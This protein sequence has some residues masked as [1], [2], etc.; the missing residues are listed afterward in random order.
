MKNKYIRFLSLF[1]VCVTAFTRAQT[2]Y[3]YT[4]KPMFQLSIK[5]AGIPIGSFTV[6]LFPNI[7]PKHTRNFDSLVSQKFYDTTA[8]HR[9]I[10]G[11]MIQGGDPNSRHGATSTW[12]YGQ[13]GQP[14]VQ[15]EFSKAKHLRG[16]LS[17][18][19]LANNVNS[20]TSQFF[21]CVAAAP[22]LDGNY[23]IYGRVTKNM[24]LVDTIVNAPRNAQDR[25][26]LKHE[27]F[28]TYIGSN[29]TVPMA[30]TLLQPKM[31][32]VGIDSTMLLQLKWKAVSDGIIYNVEV[33]HDSTFATT[34][35]AY[36]VGSTLA[37]FNHMAGNTRYYWRVRTNN[38]GHFS[39]WTQAWR[40]H[41]AGQTTGLASVAANDNN[42]RVFPNPGDEHFNFVNLNPGSRIL[43]YDETGKLVSDTVSTTRSYH[44][45]LPPKA[46]GYY[47]YS[48][49]LNN[50]E[51]AK[52]KLLLR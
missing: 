14:T 46:K 18:A 8:F 10:P 23:S 6:E 2:T 32:S 35:T 11:F 4:G 39:Q 1:F 19:R 22:S 24:S 42:I 25:P 9:V 33:S 28:V 44:L 45:T 21:I 52:G 7:A 17:A 34:D 26:N 41:T 50:R 15:A 48:V 47:T 36:N 5:R 3:T 29:D 38:G 13:P 20:A 27:M 43:V 30:P 31:D 51:V 49:H 40:F 16:I 37:N 12:G